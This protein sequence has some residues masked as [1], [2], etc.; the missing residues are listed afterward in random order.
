[1][2]S[3]IPAPNFVLPNQDSKS[4]KLD[5]FRGRTIILFAFP[6]AATSG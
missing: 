4:A 6:E 1:M 3:G 2:A 5:D